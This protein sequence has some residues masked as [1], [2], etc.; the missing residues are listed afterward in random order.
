MPYHIEICT[1]PTCQR[2]FHVTESGAEPGGDETLR[3]VP[4]PYC[5][6]VRLVLTRRGL[7]TSRLSRVDEALWRAANRIP[8][9][10]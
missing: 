9:E 3:E 2:P 7:T 8:P 4:C 10:H 6:D 5:G 1:E